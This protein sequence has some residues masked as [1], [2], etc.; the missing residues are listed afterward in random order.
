MQ[1]SLF[2]KHKNKSFL[3]VREGKRKPFSNNS[4]DD[5]F[6]SQINCLDKFS[7]SII[8]DLLSLHKLF[9]MPSKYSIS[10]YV[11]LLAIVYIL[12][13]TTLNLLTNFV[14]I[15]IFQI[16]YGFINMRSPPYQNTCSRY[17]ELTN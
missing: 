8:F 1:F 6:R 14:I 17:S 11:P 3:G 16:D 2:Q 9:Q 13:K 15:L 12:I 10:M 4:A 7:L 5:C